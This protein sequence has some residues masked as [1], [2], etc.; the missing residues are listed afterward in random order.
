VK[1]DGSKALRA[2]GLAC[3]MS[4]AM[5]LAACGASPSLSCHVTVVFGNTKGQAKSMSTA[6]SYNDVATIDASTMSATFSSSGGIISDSGVM[7]VDLLSGGS[8]IA[9]GTF[10]TVRNGNTFTAADPTALSNWVH[11]YAG[12]ADEVDVSIDNVELQDV[13]GTNSLTVTATSNGSTVTTASSTWQGLNYQH[14]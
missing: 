2:A 4:L 6:L 12:S 14:Y 8:V 13:Q 7:T 5:V 11:T 3:A 1:I 9:T 10:N